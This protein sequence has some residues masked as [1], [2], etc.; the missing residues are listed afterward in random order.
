MRYL[1]FSF[2]LL[3]FFSCKNDANQSAFGAS[4]TEIIKDNTA[5][6]NP[7]TL[8][9]P[10]AKDLL[11]PAELQQILSTPSEVTAKESTSPSDSGATSCFFRWEDQDIPNAAILLKVSTNPV[12]EEYPEY[13]SQFISKKIRD[14]ETT[15]GKD[16]PDKYVE[17]NADGIRGAYSYSQ[18]Y[19]Y[20]TVDNNYIFWLAFNTPNLSEK[21][22]TAA[23][24]KIIIA[25]NKNFQKIKS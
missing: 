18:A 21:E 20:W 23:A 13:V 5:P 22:M 6:A 11:D 9:I 14:G 7:Q 10:H 16:E 1:L 3:M 8:T 19:F 24:K 17:F 15:L 4:T 2:L 12:Y 25:A